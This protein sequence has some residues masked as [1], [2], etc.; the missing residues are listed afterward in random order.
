MKS[1]FAITTPHFSY[2]V[3]GSP[4]LMELKQAAPDRPMEGPLGE[5]WE[6][7]ALAEGPSQFLG[8]P[9]PVGSLSYLI[10]LIGTSQALSVQVH[11]GDESGVPGKTECWVI[12]E[13]QPGAHLY[14]GLKSEVSAKEFTDALEANLDL[15]PLMNVFHVQRGD[16]FWVPAGTLHALGPGLQ[17]AEVQQA[18]GVTYRVWDWNRPVDPLHPR[19]LHKKEALA[20]MTYGSQQSFRTRHDLLASTHLELARHRDFRL[21]SLNL[22]EGE[23]WT[24]QRS[25]ERAVSFM[26]LEGT[27]EL[28]RSSDSLKLDGLQ[29]AL[30]TDVS[31]DQVRVQ[32]QKGNLWL[33]IIS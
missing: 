18:S 24:W 32:N 31:T 9:I 27:A 3:W 11:P 17:L 33:L 29:T 30:L 8:A 19:P 26:L 15:T 28:Y 1:G 6:V 14:L 23:E 20:V 12:T 25:S 16:F 4:A 7:S 21:E 5:S 10:K 22:K 2:K 13:A